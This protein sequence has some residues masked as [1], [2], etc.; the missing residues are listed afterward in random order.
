MNTGGG[1]DV[2]AHSTVL[3]R[4]GSVGP[5][6]SQKVAFDTPEDRRIRRIAVGNIQ[7]V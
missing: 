5:V 2:F 1:K 3:E 7:T 4:A 6:G